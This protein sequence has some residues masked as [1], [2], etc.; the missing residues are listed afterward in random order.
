MPRHF[1]DRQLILIRNAQG[2]NLPV[3]APRKP[4]E[5]P[6]ESQSQCALIRW[7]HHACA[8][9]RV[10]EHLLMAIPLQAAR[11]P[12]NGAR[13]KA[14][15][16]RKGTLDLQL[17]VS[18]NGASGLWIEMKTQTGRLTPE[19]KIMII[20]LRR[21]GYTVEVCRSTAEAIKAIEIYLALRQ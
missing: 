13:M 5:G 20:D 16:A 12:M 21:E 15:G 3:P 7:W 10:P 11:S 2:E 8:G 14:E 1:T 17:T 9:Y 4:R 6:S 19:Q 18:R